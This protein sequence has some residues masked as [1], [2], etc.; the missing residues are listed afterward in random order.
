M[1]MGRAQEHGMKL[2]RSDDVMDIAPA[3]GEKAPIFPAPERY[4]DS[5]FSHCALSSAF[6]HRC[7]RQPAPI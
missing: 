5:I 6:L 3:T 2:P 4:P 7:K 1:G